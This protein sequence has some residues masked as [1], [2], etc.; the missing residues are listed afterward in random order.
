ML[1]TGD[2]ENESILCVPK[3][4]LLFSLNRN[5]ERNGTEYGF[6][7][8][9][10]CTETQNKKADKIDRDCVVVEYYGREDSK[11]CCRK[12]GE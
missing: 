10:E 3:G 12:R 2:R 7:E 6:Q 11:S 5:E 1:I 8:Y 9:K 4:L